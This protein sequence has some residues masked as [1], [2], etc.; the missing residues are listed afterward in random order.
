MTGFALNTTIPGCDSHFLGR[1]I[2]IGWGKGYFHVHP[3]LNILLSKEK[4][5]GLVSGTGKKQEGFGGIEIPIPP[6][7]A[8]GFRFILRGPG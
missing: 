4:S 6:A 1:K 8:G 3:T 2:S 7:P 5:F